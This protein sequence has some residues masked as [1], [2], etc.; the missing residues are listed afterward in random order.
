MFKSSSRLTDSG[1][2]DFCR[3]RSFVPVS[4][5]KKIFVAAWNGMN[6]SGTS[7]FCPPASNGI[8]EGVFAGWMLG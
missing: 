1:I 4:S 5:T 6:G 8:T 2:A 7:I 3:T